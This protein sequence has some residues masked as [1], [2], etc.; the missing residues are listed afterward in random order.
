[1]LHLE[2][3][4][5]AIDKYI[6]ASDKDLYSVKYLENLMEDYKRREKSEVRLKY[7]IGVKNEIAKYMVSDKKH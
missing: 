1:M 2:T 4:Y 5:F 6:F 7:E 3:G